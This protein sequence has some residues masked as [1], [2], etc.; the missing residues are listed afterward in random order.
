MAFESEAT[1]DLT[2]NIAGVLLDNPVMTASGTFGYGREYS[3]LVDL[4][5]LGAIV[6][7]GLSLA[8]AKGNPPPRIAETPCGMLNAI[9]LENVGFDVF[10]EKKLPYLKTLSTPTW[11]NIYGKTIEEYSTL[12]RRVDDVEGIAGIE[13]NISCPNV[14]VGGVAFGVDEQMAFEVVRA[15]RQQ[16]GRPLM[17]KL[18]PNVTEITRIAQSAVDAGA[19]ALSLIN[20]ITGMAIDIHRRRSKIANITGGLSGPAIKP[21]A[22]RMVWQVAQMSSVPVVGIGGIATAEDA[23]E[24]LIAG[25]AAVQIG[26]ANF[27]DPGCAV[28]VVDGIRKYMID[29]GIGR[30][31]ELIGTLEI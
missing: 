20:T 7:K 15:V 29:H 14:K 2:T 31:T 30:L 18:S 26:T 23:L 4:N 24:F 8:P 10:V 17:V 11:V 1:P 5:R 25:A 13:L 9:G 3:Q 19:D 16:T 22:L 21:V 6:V 28:R 12:A 27:V